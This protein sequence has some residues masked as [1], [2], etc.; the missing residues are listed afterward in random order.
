LASP[1]AAARPGRHEA[2]AR[3][4]Q[5]QRRLGGASSSAPRGKRERK[6]KE[7]RE[8]RKKR[9]R[10]KIDYVMY[11]LFKYRIKI[12]TSIAFKNNIAP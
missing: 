3:G 7:K 8:K 2:T 1:R 11:I 10:M 12:C 4:Q 9:K 5:K 6:K